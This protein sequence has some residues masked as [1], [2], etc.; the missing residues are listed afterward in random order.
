M[1][2]KQLGVF[3]SVA[4]LATA[5]FSLTA[6]QAAC[7]KS[8]A[9]RHSPGAYFVPPPPPYA[10]SILPERLV[11]HAAAAQVED[12]EAVKPPENPY[13][14]YIFTRNAGDMPRVVQNPRTGT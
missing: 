1:A 5:W 4:L 14:K 8:K 6:D 12:A 3:F 11:R 13:A 10:P 2:A 7:A 9:R